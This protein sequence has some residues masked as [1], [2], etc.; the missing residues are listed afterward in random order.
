MD[1]T[2]NIFWHWCL[3]W[4]Q[5]FIIEGKVI[6]NFSLATHKEVTGVYWVVQ[7]YL[8]LEMKFLLSSMGYEFIPERWELIYL[9]HI[10]FVAL[11]MLL[12]AIK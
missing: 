2:I 8:Q 6:P 10:H 3:S 11:K 9:Y 7:S 4:G 5:F 12:V 1:S